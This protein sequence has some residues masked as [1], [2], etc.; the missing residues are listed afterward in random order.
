MGHKLHAAAAPSHNDGAAAPDFPYTAQL[1]PG[2][3]HIF[4]TY[5]KTKDKLPRLKLLASIMSASSMSNNSIRYAL[6]R[7]FTS[8]FSREKF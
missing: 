4:S 6:K 3:S 7:E 5:M 8:C 1:K 2:N